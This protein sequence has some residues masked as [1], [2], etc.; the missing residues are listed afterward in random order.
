VKE[1]LI[2]ESEARHLRRSVSEGVVSPFEDVF[3]DAVF[4]CFV[5]FGE[6]SGCE[7]GCCGHG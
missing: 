3:G 5:Y 4:E 1:G 2:F 7:A 6:L